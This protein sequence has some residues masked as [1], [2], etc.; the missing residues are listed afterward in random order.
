MNDIV[1]DLRKQVQGEVC[2][3]KYSRIL[4]STDASIYELEPMGVVIPKSAEDIQATIELA[5]KYGVSIT[6]RGGGTSL[7]GGSIGEGIIVDCSKYLNSILEVN[8]EESWARIQPGVVLDQLNNHLQPYGLLFAPDVATSSRANICGMIGNNS[9]GA[10][11]LV[12]GKTIDHVLELTVLLSNGEEATL[13]ASTAAEWRNRLG[14]P[15]F[16]NSL[17]TKVDELVGTHRDEIDKRFPKILRRVAGYNLDEFV[18]KDHH[19]LAKLIVGSEGT[20]AVVTEAKVNLV[21][22]KKHCVVAVVHFDDMYSAL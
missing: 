16:L 18:R 22:L 2:F 19:N 3:D 17:Y 4:Y 13:S 15:G 10:H 11:S 8:Q 20:L 6:P 5:G 12:Y 1:H 14:K 7:V 9:S 21:P